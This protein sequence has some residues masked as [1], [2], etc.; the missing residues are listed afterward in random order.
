MGEDCL[1]TDV[2]RTITAV[3]STC[4]NRHAR[5]R[6]L[7]FFDRLQTRLVWPYHRSL[8]KLP[9]L[10]HRKKT[11]TITKLSQR[12]ARQMFRVV[13]FKPPVCRTIWHTESIGDLVLATC[14]LVEGRDVD[15]SMHWHTE[16]AMRMMFP[17]WSLAV[18]ILVRERLEGR[19]EELRLQTGNR[20]T[21][22]ANMKKASVGRGGG[23]RAIVVQG[24]GRTRDGGTAPIGSAGT[25]PRN[26]RQ[27]AEE[28][29]ATWL[30]EIPSRRDRRTGC[31]MEHPHLGTRRQAQVKEALIRDLRERARDWNGAARSMC[32]GRGD[33]HDDRISPG[34]FPETS[35]GD[36]RRCSHDSDGS[37]TLTTVLAVLESSRGRTTRRILSP[38]WEPGG[39]W[40]QQG[41]ETSNPEEKDKLPREQPMASGQKRR[42]ESGPAIFFAVMALQLGTH[43]AY[44]GGWSRM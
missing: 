27:G 9:R 25:P 2:V 19:C 13:I 8:I 36:G 14:F 35:T 22:M 31:R 7:P 5:D 10:P 40:P 42:W 38:T 24:Q 3:T 23:D 39:G 28:T 17:P 43:V 18:Q 32:G 29:T 41:V 34:E 33:H 4:G 6:R 26:S 1:V 12:T 37:M 16:C 11:L 21:T 15:P 30:E 20:P 44:E